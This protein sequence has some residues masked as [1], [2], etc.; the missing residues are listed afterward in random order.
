LVEKILSSLNHIVI[1]ARN[2]QEVV[3][4]CKELKGADIILMDLNMPVMDGYA[5]A[6]IVK[7]EWPGTPLVALTAYAGEDERIR[8]TTAGFSKFIAKPFDKDM[9]LSTI[10]ELVN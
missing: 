2:G 1:R 7:K 5:A 4:L 10:S 9:L 6:E 3:K 8:A